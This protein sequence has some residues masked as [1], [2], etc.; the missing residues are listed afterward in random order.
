MTQKSFNPFGQP[1]PPV[2][3][4]RALADLISSVQPPNKYQTLLGLGKESVPAPPM[5]YTSAEIAEE[6]RAIFKETWTTRIGD[7]VP[8]SEDLKLSNDGV[9]LNGTILY[10]DL[11]DST[12]MVDSMKPEFAAE[13]YKAFLKGACR[14]IRNN[15]GEIIAF[16]GDRV[17]AVYIGNSKNTSAAKSALQI[18]RVVTD[19]NASLKAQYPN[20]D[21]KI[22]HVV[23]ID[24]SSLFVAKTGIRKDNDLVWVGRAA[25]RAAKLCTI[26]EDYE[27]S[28]IT[29]EVYNM[30]HEEAKFDAASKKLMWRERTWSAMNNIPIYSSTWYWGSF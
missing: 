23:G 10:A 28:Y 9:T 8:E 18:N 2:H 21:F 27:R 11:V 25:N 7:K 15:G 29:P 5:R 17:M 24:T 19:A 12:G 26:R 6:I 20:T 22:R 3:S 4:A 14:V 30:L 16:D 13:V 1:L